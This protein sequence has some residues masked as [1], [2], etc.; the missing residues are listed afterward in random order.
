MNLDI[1]KLNFFILTQKNQILVYLQAFD[2]IVEAIAREKNLKNYK[3]NWKIEL[4]TKHNPEWNELVLLGRLRLH[5]LINAFD[6]F[7]EIAAR[8]CNDVLNEKID[9][10]L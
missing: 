6:A 3:R 10:P 5:R 9:S 8:D 4:I 7:A 1:T 2:S